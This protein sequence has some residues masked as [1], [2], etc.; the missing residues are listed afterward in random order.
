MGGRHMYVAHLISQL[1]DLEQAAASAQITLL[2]LVRPAHNSRTTR[3]RHPVIIR[4]PQPPERSNARLREEVLREVRHA[5][6][7]N[8]NVRLERDDLGAHVLDVLL[9]HAE[10]GVPVLHKHECEPTR[11]HV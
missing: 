2:D 11:V 7:R 5:L 4:L 6:L 8:D 3:P 1:P 9:L 10:H